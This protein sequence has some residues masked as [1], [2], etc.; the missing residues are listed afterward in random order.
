MDGITHFLFTPKIQD[1]NSKTALIQSINSAH[2][3]ANSFP[4]RTS[5]QQ[6]C[7]NTPEQ[8]NPKRDKEA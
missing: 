1:A 6:K 2:H 5:G 7:R 8:T 3:V 4:D